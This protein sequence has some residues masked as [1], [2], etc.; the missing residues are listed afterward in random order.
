MTSAKR[1]SAVLFQ[2]FSV[3][4]LLV[5]CRRLAGAAA[6]A[7][8]VGHRPPPRVSE[9]SVRLAFWFVGVATGR[10]M[11]W[12]AKINIAIAYQLWT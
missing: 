3:R 7:L 10:V 4:V 1:T 5:A 6:L 8:F 9:A 12:A 2:Q 11:R